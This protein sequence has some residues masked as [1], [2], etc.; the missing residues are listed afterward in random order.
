MVGYRVWG[1]RCRAEL[2]S[3][4]SSS[5]PGGSLPTRSV[6]TNLSRPP[7]SRSHVIKFVPEKSLKSTSS[8]KGDFRKQCFS[9]KPCVPSSVGKSCQACTPCQDVAGTIKAPS[10]FSALM[11]CKNDI[12]K[13]VRA[14]RCFNEAVPGLHP[15]PLTLK[16]DRVELLG[17][18]EKGIQTPMA[19]GRSTKIISMI[20]LIRTSILSMKKSL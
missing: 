12:G 19:Q 17:Y 6:S 4:P 5:R 8:G 9:P 3:P 16:P 10:S 2:E 11:L 7:K 13:R 18:L 20:K 1:K 14:A 15:H